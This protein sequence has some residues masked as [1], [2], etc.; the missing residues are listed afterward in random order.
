ME[1]VLNLKYFEFEISYY[2][3]NKSESGCGNR[4]KIIHIMKEVIMRFSLDEMVKI[5][6][7]KV[8]YSNNASGMFSLSTDTRY[9]SPDQVY[10]PLK[11]ENFDGHNFIKDAIEKSARGFFIE[12]SELERLKTLPKTKFALEVTNTKEAYLA[13]A[14]SYKDKISPIVV[15]VTGSSGKTTVK[16]MVSAVLEAKYNVHRTKLNFNNEIGVAQTMFEMP[17]QTDVL[18]LE[19]GMRGLGEIELLSKYAK[20]DVAIITNIGLAHVGKLGSKENIAKAK[21]EIVKYLHNEGVLVSCEDELVKKNIRAKYQIYYSLED[22]NLKNIQKTSESVS[23]EYKKQTYKLNVIG[24][25]NILN[26]LCAIE[27]GQKLGVS[28]VAI[29]KALGEYVPLS[30]R[31]E[32]LQIGKLALINDYYNANPESMKASI[33]AALDAYGEIS[34]ILG[35]MGELGEKE[36]FYHREI[37]KFL[38]DKKIKTLVVV[39]RLAKNIAKTAKIADTQIFRDTKEVVEYLENIDENRAWL[40]KASRSMKFEDIVTQLKGQIA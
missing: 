11:G 30:N 28:T 32:V 35:D 23:F 4:N 24:D 38:Q 40:L 3:E 26:A 36:V 33:Q 20:P 5:T 1:F 21:C 39:G 25:Y 8:L 9:I 18:V 16:E 27:V 14:G 6:G 29:S 13:L 10:I 15:A 12:T 31:G 34:L 2:F 19:M 37:G 22:K 7:A 17:G